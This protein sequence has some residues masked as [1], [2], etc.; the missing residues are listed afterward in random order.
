MVI[1][2]AAR[3]FLLWFTIVASFVLTVCVI[4]LSEISVVYP[5]LMGGMAFWSIYHNTRRKRRYVLPTLWSLFFILGYILSY[6]SVLIDPEKA[7]V[8]PRKDLSLFLF[9]DSS[10]FPVFWVM[11]TG[12]AG[13]TLAVSFWEKLY[14][15]S[16]T[17]LSTANPNPI[18]L[19]LPQNFNQ[20]TNN[21]RAF[22][23]AL[24]S[25]FSWLWML[26]SLLI[27]GVMWT[28]GIGRTG[29]SHVTELPFMIGGGLVYIKNMVIP[30]LG[31]VVFVAAVSTHDYRQLRINFLMLLL[32]GGVG[33]VAF[34]SRGFF[35]F[36]IVP[37]LIY[38][39]AVSILV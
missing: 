29:L 20:V 36:M 4:T 38:L 17:R 30:F 18:T 1:Y 13:M 33:S 25:Q 3:R 24:L 16:R 7:G 23:T 37:A 12:M 2:P 32:V 34:V 21:N 14:G 15:R 9:T 11:V 8:G 27:I 6:A 19:S 26:S 39:E 5:L 22:S 31:F 10:F 28:L 35:V